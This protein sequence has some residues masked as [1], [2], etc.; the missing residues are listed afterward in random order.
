LHA[1]KNVCITTFTLNRTISAGTGFYENVCSTAA[2]FGIL[3]GD[4]FRLLFAYDPDTSVQGRTRPTNEYYW[5][6]YPLEDL[7]ISLFVNSGSGFELH[8]DSPYDSYVMKVYDDS[9]VD[10]VAR[11]NAYLPH[12]TTLAFQLFD[13]DP[14]VLNGDVCPEIVWERFSRAAIHCS[15]RDYATREYYKFHGTITAATV[16]PQEPPIQIVDID[17]KPGSDRN[18]INLKS[19]G[20]VPVALLGAEDFDVTC[21]EDPLAVELFGAELLDTANENYKPAKPIHFV[22]EDLNWDGYDDILFHFS[23]QDL[24]VGLG[25]GTKEVCLAFTI[26]EYLFAGT[27]TVDAFLKGKKTGKKK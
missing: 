7:G 27:D 21:L 26:G 3:P 25:E 10:V 8:T 14:F 24:A 1:R 2:F 19:K 4:E 6:D 11:L 5:H 20:M 13:L 18:P 15:V 23:T 16:I 12:Y 22:V 9:H 17:V